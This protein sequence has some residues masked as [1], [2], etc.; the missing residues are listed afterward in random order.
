MT[1]AKFASVATDDQS[2]DNLKN[3]RNP[4]NII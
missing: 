3:R 1:V 2:E 4:K